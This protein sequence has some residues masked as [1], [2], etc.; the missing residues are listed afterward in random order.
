MSETISVAVAANESFSVALCVAIY[1]LLE[2]LR[3]EIEV[4]LYVM[5]SD[6]RA[7]TRHRLEKTWDERVRPHWVSP[8]DRKVHALVAGIGHTASPSA[9]YRLFIGSMLPA[10]LTK[11]IYLDVDVLVRGMSIISGGGR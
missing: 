9:Y 4:D 1:T 7:E 6:I 10:S 11:V 3:R 8:D 5:A 2:N